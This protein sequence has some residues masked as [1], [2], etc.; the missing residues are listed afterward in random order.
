MKTKNCGICSKQSARKHR[1]QGHFVRTCSWNPSRYQWFRERPTWWKEGRNASQSKIMADILGYKGGH[2]IELSHGAGK[3]GVEKVV[4]VDE[5]DTH[6]PSI[7]RNG[8][9]GKMSRP[10]GRVVFAELDKADPDSDGFYATAILSKDEYPNVFAAMHNIKAGDRFWPKRRNQH[11]KPYTVLGY[12]AG[13]QDVM[14]TRDGWTTA[15][16]TSQAM[17]LTLIGKRVEN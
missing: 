14:F 1:R 10:I 16:S 6:V 12:M 11:S 3:T 5:H 7:V 17:F 9:F 13:T 8:T 4:I 2:R 15:D